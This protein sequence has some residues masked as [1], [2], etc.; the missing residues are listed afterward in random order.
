[1]RKDT[2]TITPRQR[3]S[4][5]PFVVGVADRNHR[6]GT[7]TPTMLPEIGLPTSLLLKCEHRAVHS[8]EQLRVFSVLYST[9]HTT[10]EQLP[11]A[12]NPPDADMKSGTLALLLNGTR[13]LSILFLLASPA[14]APFCY[15]CSLL[16]LP[17][18]ALRCPLSPLYTR[19]AARSCTSQPENE[20]QRGKVGRKESPMLCARGRAGK[21]TVSS[22]G[23]CSHRLA[24]V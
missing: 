22:A 16:L 12:D 19:Q 23:G 20:R 13:S 11:L 6:G 15:C 1:M 14:S 24:R 5:N 21:D 4:A 18:S 3:S 10:A 9:S 2:R 17:R 7:T 8:T